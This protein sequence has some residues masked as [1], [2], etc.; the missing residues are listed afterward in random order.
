M[1]L[2]HG[3]CY[4]SGVLSPVRNVVLFAFAF[5][6]FAAPS[7]CPTV[8]AHPQ[9]GLSTVNRYVR[10]VLLKDKTLI[11]YTL[12]VGEVPAGELLR[13]ADMNRDGV[14]SVSEKKQLSAWLAQTLSRNVTITLNGEKRALLFEDPQLSLKTPE[15]RATPFALE[16]TAIVSFPAMKGVHRL[17]LEDRADLPPVGEIETRIEASPEVVLLS[18]T[19]I[20]GVEKEPFGNDNQAAQKESSGLITLFRQY[21]PPRSVLSDRS[22]SVRFQEKEIRS[23]PQTGSFRRMG[24]VGIAVLT[25]LFGLIALFGRR[26]RSV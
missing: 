15:V 7:L 4:V 10:L 13:N 23:V 12:M 5:L 8:R 14:L 20:G 1:Y 26:N 17:S 3:L 24:L 22:I 16:G 11:Q 25:V 21:G 6:L 18:S 9:F 2:G 19:G